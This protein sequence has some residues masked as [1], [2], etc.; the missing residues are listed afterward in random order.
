MNDIG[1]KVKKFYEKTP[2]NF[3]DSPAI[4]EKKIRERNLILDYAPL[5]KE[6]LYKSKV[7]ELGCGSGWLSLCL[8]HYYK[9]EV[10]AI[11]FNQKSINIAQAAQ[12]LLKTNVKFI[13]ADFTKEFLNEKFNWVISVGVL[14]HTAH[15]MTN[16]DALIKH[17]LDDQGNILVGLYHLHGR[18]P[19]LD[20]IEQLKNSTQ[21]EAVLME[22][23]RKIDQR[24][25]LNEEEYFLSWFADQVL[26]P[27]ESQHTLEEVMNVFD[28]NKITHRG[29]SINQFKSERLR[30]IIENE[31]ALEIK[32]KKNIQKGI[33]DPGF[34]TVLGER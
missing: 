24:F 1:S 3:P 25:L 26:H 29:T 17:Y 13:C 23:Y 2:F 27:F 15:A 28:K 20:K 34:F 4:I 9:C 30:D 8:S 31:S 18:R 14:H 21:D 7:I 32:A 5:T 10:T 11:D 19:F 16:L 6:K 12:N 22:A 33:F